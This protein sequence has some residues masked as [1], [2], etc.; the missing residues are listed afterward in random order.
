VEGLI[1][2]FNHIGGV[3]Y[4]I[5][6]DNPATIV[7]KVLKDG[8]RVLNE[9]F[10]RFKNHYCFTSAF[11]NVGK[12]NEKGNVE[13]KVG[14]LRR[15]LLVPV[16]RFDDLRTFNQRLLERCDEDMN[17]PHYKKETL[18]ADLF[19]EDRTRFLPLPTMYIN[20]NLLSPSSTSYIFFRCHTGMGRFYR[21]SFRSE[22]RKYQPC[23]D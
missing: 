20:L 12:G 10:T 5:W 17:R 6:F 2:I 16:P 8:E 19:A 21:L 9:T 7:N 22:N 15:N 14:Y 13:N 18:I 3:P 1:N 23:E 11:C 4:R